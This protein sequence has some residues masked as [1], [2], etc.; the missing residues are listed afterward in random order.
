MGKTT[1]SKAIVLYFQKEIEG[2]TY[3]EN[4]PLPPEPWICE[5]FE[6]SHMTVNK[7]MNELAAKGYVKRIPG[8]GSFV[9]H[10]YK[11][12]INKAL[13]MSESSTELVRRSGQTPRTKLIKY[14]LI[15]ASD[16]AETKGFFSAS[17]KYI[18]HFVRGRYANDKLICI[19]Y[20]YVSSLIIPHIEISKLEESFTKYTQELGITRSSGHME[21]CAKL[22]TDQ[23]AKLIGT[24]NIPLLKQS[25]YWY[26][27]GQPMEVT[28]H[29][30]IGDQY[31][32]TQDFSLKYNAD[33][34]AD[35]TILNEHRKKELSSM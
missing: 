17:E 23:Q 18:H 29:Y 11:R 14:S 20:T 33:G 4:E 2:G 12:S 9:S 13:T 6:S 16:A 3:K 32:V 30:F 5:K 25:I 10:D 7:A 35:K 31:S 22:P 27:N 24:K 15:Q 26:S 1:K 28:F 8:N 19:S 21:L 34:T